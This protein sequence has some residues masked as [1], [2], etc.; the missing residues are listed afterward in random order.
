[1]VS[2]TAGLLNERD[3]AGY[4]DQ[5]VT[6]LRWWRYAGAGPRFVKLGANVRYRQVDLDAFIEQN[7]R[8]STTDR[9][10]GRLRP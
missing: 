5:K 10:P 9:A 8:C 1:M 7:V 3:A 2:L 4:L 6:T